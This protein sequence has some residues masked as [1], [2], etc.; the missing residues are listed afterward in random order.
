M[1][2]VEKNVAHYVQKHT[3]LVTILVVSI[4]L[5]LAIGEYFLYRK[6]MLVNSMVS[7]GLM[8]IKEQRRSKRNFDEDRVTK[9]GG[10]MMMNRDGIEKMLEENL[11][12]GDGT[13]VDKKGEVV[14]PDGSKMMLN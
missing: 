11:M 4:F 3:F 9:R 8:Q 13:R 5:L 10:K 7:E 2:N 12:M 6:I 14:N 1:E